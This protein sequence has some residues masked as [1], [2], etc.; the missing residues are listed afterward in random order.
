M[1]I[2]IRMVAFASAR[3]SGE[4]L[5]DPKRQLWRSLEFPLAH[6]LQF[7]ISSST[8]CIFVSKFRKVLR[9]CENGRMNMISMGLY[10]FNKML[11]SCC[12]WVSHAMHMALKWFLWLPWFYDVFFNFY[13]VCNLF[14]IRFPMYVYNVCMIFNCVYMILV[15]FFKCFSYDM[16]FS[17]DFICF[18]MVSYGFRMILY[19]FIWFYIVFVWFY[20]LFYMFLYV[21]YDVFDMLFS[22]VPVTAWVHRGSTLGPSWALLAGFL[23]PA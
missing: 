11:I 19:G 13:L 20:M 5:L 17:Y 9:I 12:I 15:W 8:R 1:N 14:F 7:S 22:L 6:V 21:F 4:P 18:H 23:G 2:H 10:D 3:N 16:C